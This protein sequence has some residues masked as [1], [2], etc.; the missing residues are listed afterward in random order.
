LLGEEIMIVTTTENIPG[1]EIETLEIVFGN[2][3]RAKHVG[4]TLWLA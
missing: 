4:K 3:V 1:Y 2:T